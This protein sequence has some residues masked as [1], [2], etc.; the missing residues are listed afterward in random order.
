MSLAFVVPTR[1]RG[2]AASAGAAVLAAILVACMGSESAPVQ[3]PGDVH[4]TTHQIDQASGSNII[5]IAWSQQSGVEGYSVDFKPGADY[6]P[7]TGVDLPGDATVAISRPL[8]PRTWY[9]HLRTLGNNGE[10]TGA[11]H[12]GPFV[13][14]GPGDNPLGTPGP[15]PTPTPAAP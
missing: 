9:F 3:N 12:L 4:S 2:V 1:V 14:I 13:V 5:R 6:V 10:W 8:P 15:S 11:I 7:D